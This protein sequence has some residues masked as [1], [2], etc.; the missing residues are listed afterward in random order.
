MAEELTTEATELLENHYG[1][2][3]RAVMPARMAAP[4]V[5]FA[6]PEP[7]LVDAIEDSALSFGLDP[8]TV[9]W[10]TVIPQIIAAMTGNPWSILPLFLKYGPAFIKLVQ[11]IVAM[12]HK[13]ATPTPGGGP[14]INPA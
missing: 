4:Q 6:P 10:A 2:Q 14:V 13:P 1:H 5:A 9:D 11:S 3:V 7:E 12:F 8:A